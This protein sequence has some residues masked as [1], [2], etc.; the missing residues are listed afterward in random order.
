VDAVIQ[1]IDMLV[2]WDEFRLPREASMP[3]NQEDRGDEDGDEEGEY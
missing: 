3:G 2:Q 1:Q